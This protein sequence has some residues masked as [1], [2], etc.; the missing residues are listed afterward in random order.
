[1]GDPCPNFCLCAFLG[2]Y[3]VNQVLQPQTRKALDLNS[4]PCISKSP[5]QNMPFGTQLPLLLA[6]A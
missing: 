5:K 2:P 6:L 3:K 1:M 4:D